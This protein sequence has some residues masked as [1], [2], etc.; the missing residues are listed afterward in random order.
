M[1]EISNRSGFHPP[2]PFGRLPFGSPVH[3]AARVFHRPLKGTVPKGESLVRARVH[4]SPSRLA[5]RPANKA[6]QDLPMSRAR[7]NDLVV[8]C[9]FPPILSTKGQPLCP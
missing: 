4:L 2:Y 1:A 8:S 5:A 6:H 3:D 7:A 9:P